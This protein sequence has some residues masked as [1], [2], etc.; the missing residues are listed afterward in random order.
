MYDIMEQGVTL[1]EPLYLR[2]E[3]QPTMEAVYYL[4]PTEASVDCVIRDF[5]QND[6]QYAGAHLLFTKRLP[7]ELFSRI[8]SSKV[9][10][11]IRS[12]REIYID[13]L[14]YEQ[15]VVHL[16][17]QQ[18]VWN[19]YSPHST[20]KD[21]QIRRVADK[22]LTVFATLEQEPIIRFGSG[23]HLSSSLATLL[24]E[25]IDT[26][27]SQTQ[28][29]PR[30]VFCVVALSPVCTCRSQRANQTARRNRVRFF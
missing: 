11:K 18:A 12:L 15:R 23:H 5:E 19:L 21:A 8:K 10:N 17:M 22:L 2:R 4:S 26:F 28:G 14:A 9:K 20:Q 24:K 6:Q 3:P 25:R 1:V 13:Y 16:D 29:W 7:D 27:K 30:C